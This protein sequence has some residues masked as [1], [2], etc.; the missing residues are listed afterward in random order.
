MQGY[1]IKFNHI[2]KHTAQWDEP[3]QSTHE[4]TAAQQ[5][6]WL[7]RWENRK[8]AQPVAK[9]LLHVVIMLWSV[10]GSVN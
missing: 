6:A 7:K 10:T 9:Q 1:G 4:H 8:G 2:T 3:H 5:T